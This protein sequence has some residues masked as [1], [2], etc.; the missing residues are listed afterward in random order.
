MSK[1]EQIESLSLELEMTS[2]DVEVE[3]ECVEMI[4]LYEIPV[5]VSL[6]GWEDY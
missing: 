4:D 3:S 2:I 5:R 6:D 1:Q